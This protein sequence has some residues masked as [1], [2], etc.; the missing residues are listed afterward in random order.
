MGQAH[1]GEQN[2]NASLSRQQVAEIKWLLGEGYGASWVAN[3]YDYPVGVAGVRS[4]MKERTWADVDPV[5]PE[6]R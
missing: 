6:G 2:P 5:A 1:P 3:A 4:I